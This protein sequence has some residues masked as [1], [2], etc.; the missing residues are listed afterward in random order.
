MFDATKINPNNYAGFKEIQ[1]KR[2]SCPA[3][4]MWL[5]EGFFIEYD[6]GREIGEPGDWIMLSHSGEKFVI[7]KDL[8]DKRYDIIDGGE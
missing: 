1:E 4:Q 8:F 2:I 6:G 5:P 3:I 7:K